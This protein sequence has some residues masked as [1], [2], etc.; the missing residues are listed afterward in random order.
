M[1]KGFDEKKH[2]PPAD[3]NDIHKWKAGF[4]NLYL[5]NI[6]EN[7]FSNKTPKEHIFFMAATML[8]IAR[9]SG[10]KSS[11]MSWVHNGRTNMHEL[12]LMGLMLE[13]YPI[14][15]NFEK[16]T[17]VGD[18]LDKLEK[19]VNEGIAYRKSLKVTYDEGLQDDCAT[20]LFQKSMHADKIYIDKKPCKMIEFLPNNW[21]A[22]ENT[23]DIEINSAENGT[24]DLILDYDASKYSE[25]V[26][27]N[28]AKIMDEIILK[29]Q[30]EKILISEILC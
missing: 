14:A 27:K 20:F 18:F 24:Y 25:Q 5:K 21:S 10:A 2:L 7:F 30:D 23:L 9:S 6:D 22:A 8:T 13:Q 26:M 19:K 29:L 1:T 4:Y 12:R 17:T 3:L 11:V 28:F 15:W 16:D